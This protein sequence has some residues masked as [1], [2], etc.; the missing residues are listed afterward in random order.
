MTDVMTNPESSRLTTT[1]EAG[2][3]FFSGVVDAHTAEQLLE[4][5]QST[6]AGEDAVADLGDVEFIDSSGLRTLVTVHQ[7]HE[8]AGSQLRL[9]NLSAAVA[10]LLEITGLDDHLHID[11]K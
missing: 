11:Q 6:P 5:L 4:S 2:T 10:R 8:A 9:R 1:V 7:Q 3:H